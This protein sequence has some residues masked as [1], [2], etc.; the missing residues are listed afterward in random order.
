MRSRWI[1][2]LSLATSILAVP[3]TLLAS[4]PAAPT[5]P[6]NYPWSASQEI[7]PV[8]LAHELKAGRKLRIVCVGFPVLYD[9]AR[10]PGAAIAGPAEQAAGLKRLQAWARSIPKNEPV[11]IY[12]GCC[13]LAQ[14]PNI[15]PAYRALERA[16]LRRVRVLMLENSFARDW[17]DKGYPTKRVK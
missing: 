17:V 10:I 9:A 3:L 6:N 15:R 8:T 1:L 12:C 11:V 5:P 4:G 13:P 2:S 7:T 16:G 14:C